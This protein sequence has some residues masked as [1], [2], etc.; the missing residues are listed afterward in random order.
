MSLQYQIANY[1]SRIN[2]TGSVHWQLDSGGEFSQMLRSDLNQIIEFLPRYK[3]ELVPFIGLLS[4]K[5]FPNFAVPPKPLLLG[6][7]R[8]TL[9]YLS[10]YHRA[11][12]LSNTLLV[13]N[14][15]ASQATA[16]NSAVALCRILVT[17]KL[18][19]QDDGSN[20]KD[21]FVAGV[22]FKSMH[23]KEGIKPSVINLADT[24]NEL[25]NR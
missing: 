10:L 17:R 6:S 15:P 25:G 11:I 5:L 24:R 19:L 22:L 14:N 23:H 3:S 8:Q 13:S 4:D 1:L 18:N 7:D 2:H 20:F 16:L 21:I 9:E 12:L